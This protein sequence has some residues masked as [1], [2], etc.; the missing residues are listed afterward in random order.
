[1][2]ALSLQSYDIFGQT[3]K[4][5]GKKFVGWLFLSIFAE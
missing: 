3:G 5:K 1:M 2:V 4:E